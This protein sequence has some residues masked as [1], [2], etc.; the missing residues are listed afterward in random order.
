MAFLVCLTNLVW[1]DWKV[2]VY[3]EVV[4]QE[5][6]PVLLRVL[7]EKEVDLVLEK[8]AKVLSLVKKFH[9]VGFQQV[10]P[11]VKEVE[12]QINHRLQIHRQR[13]EKVARTL[14]Q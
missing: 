4:P 7:G 14:A 1:A 3:L 10:L 13:M 11:R 5:K 8:G 12:G 2:Q 6:G 9:L